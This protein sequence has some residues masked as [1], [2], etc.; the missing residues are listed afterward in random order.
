MYHRHM[1]RE[2]NLSSQFDYLFEP[3]DDAVSADDTIDTEPPPSRSSDE[4]TPSPSRAPV[5]MAFAAFVL[6]TLGAVAVVAV[7]LTQRP[8]VPAGPVQSPT[9]PARLSSTMR[10]R[11]SPPFRRLKP[12][13]RRRRA[14]SSQVPGS[15]VHR[16]RRRPRRSGNPRAT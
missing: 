9:E 14:P 7:L 1:P 10:R 16:T 11:R 2:D 6:G 15:R 4:A 12:S 8:S 3:L 5:T 13:P